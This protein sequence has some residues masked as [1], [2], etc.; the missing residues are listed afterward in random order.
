[1]NVYN[2]FLEEG[3]NN[4]RKGTQKGLMIFMIVGFGWMVAS[5]GGYFL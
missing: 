1:M 4:F 5:N 2:S 3:I